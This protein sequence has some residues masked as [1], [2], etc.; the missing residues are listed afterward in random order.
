MIWQTVQHTLHVHMLCG[1]R[2]SSITCK[3]SGAVLHP[4]QDADAY[5]SRQQ[6]LQTM[7]TS[8]QQQQRQ[9][10]LSVS[11]APPSQTHPDDIAALVGSYY[12]SQSSTNS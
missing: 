9:L 5:P 7:N 4:L 6:V 12:N 8:G 10:Q 3:P 11:R 1:C 2:M